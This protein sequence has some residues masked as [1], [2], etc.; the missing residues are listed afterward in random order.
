MVDEV[1]IIY[2]DSDTKR[3]EI[4]QHWMNKVLV[5][6]PKYLEWHTDIALGEQQVI[7]V[8][9]ETAKKRFNQT[10]GM[11]TDKISHI[12]ISESLGSNTPVLWF[13]K[14]SVSLPGVHIYQNIYGC[15]W[16]DQTDEVNGFD[17]DGYDGE[18]FIS[19]DVR[20][21]SWVAPKPQSVI[22]KLKWEQNKGRIAQKK[23][24]FTQVCPEWL[25]K[26]LNYGNSSLL[27]AGKT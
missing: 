6:Y 3:A 11:F 2:Y 22:S 20:T 1:Q 23:D 15:E 18:D 21:E 26:Y 19:F 12:W 4:K 27:R 10:R 7:K 17:Q 25:K 8:D 5:D 9:I 13:D 16:D 14:V 24:Y